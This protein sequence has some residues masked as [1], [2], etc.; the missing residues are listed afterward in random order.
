MLR[1]DPGQLDQILVNLAVNARDAISAGGT[2]TIETGNT[3]FDD[4]YAM[5]HF[6]VEAG[7]YV[8]LA[9]SDTGEGMDRETRE[10]IF[11]PFFTTKAQGKGTGLGLATI[12]GIVTQAGGHIW[13][14]SEPGQGSTF[15]L[16]FPRVFDA[17]AAEGPAAPAPAPVE[18]G[19]ILVVEDDA[20][21]R[22]MTT[23][24]LARA[25]FRV[26]A[27]GE[28]QEALAALA[29]RDV[30][31][32]VLVSDVVMP[33]M[34]GIELAEEIRERDP[35][36]GVVLLSGYTAETLN[37]ERVT[38]RGARF[39]SKPVSSAELLQAIQDVRAAIDQAYRSKLG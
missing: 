27:V 15:K 19:T 32:D 31:I 18:S 39:V 30:T 25:G 33:G 13:L 24:A 38:S 5:E 12:Y 4:A 10:H 23:R 35:H 34:S 6:G 20:A 26:I 1:A 21:V 28:A 2:I 9:V 14:Y 16:Y 7:P 36:V 3:A 17:V 22:D 8:F 37:L 29:R 11:E